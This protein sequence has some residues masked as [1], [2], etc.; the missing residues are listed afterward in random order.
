M[1]RIVYFLA[2]MSFMSCATQRY[3]ADEI[4]KHQII[5]GNG[6]G[7]SGQVNTFILLANG[8]RF[9]SNHLTSENKEHTSIKKSKAKEFFKAIEKLQ[10]ED[11]KLDNPGNTYKF[12]AIQTDSSIH[13]VT[14]GDSKVTVP[15]GVKTIYKELIE[16]N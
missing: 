8:Q 10:L 1:I 2:A 4:P 3:N 14:W 11:I 12:I 5:Y 6:G 16:L 9:I 7:F 15:E 13:K